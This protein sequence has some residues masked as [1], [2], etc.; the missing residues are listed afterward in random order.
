MRD[1]DGFCIRCARNEPGEA[2]G[3]ISDGSARA[4]AATS[5]ATRAPPRAKRKVL[6]DVF[7]PGDS[8]FRTGDL[9]RIDERGFYYFVD[10]VGDTFRW[11][12]ENVATAEV[13]AAL[14]AC[15]GVK[16][17]NVYG[18]GI[19]GHD[20]KAGMAALVTGDG[21]S[22]RALDA[23][24]AAHAARLC[25]TAVPAPAAR[26]RH[27][28]NIQAQEGGA[29]P[30]G[31]RPVDGR[32]SAVFSKSRS[33]RFPAAGCEPFRSD[34]LRRNPALKPAVHEKERRSYAA[35]LLQSGQCGPEPA[36]GPALDDYRSMM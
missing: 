9:M 24:V 31:L 30:R 22:L 33:G 25:A 16:D 11:K 7:K 13:A 26:N 36:P 19:P 15:P 29:G 4:T 5:R 8:W 17:A 1:A 27:D 23:H 14:M 12:G 10:R 18:V 34:R 6:R 20:G 21:F 32:G 3:L 2:I 28:R 35:P